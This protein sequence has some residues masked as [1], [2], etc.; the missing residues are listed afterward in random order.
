M[1]EHLFLL[2]RWM[3]IVNYCFLL[4]S[5]TIFSSL[6]LSYMPT[7]GLTLLSSLHIGIVEKTLLSEF[8]LHNLISYKCML[9]LLFFW[10]ISVLVEVNW[11]CGNTLKT[12]AN[13][14]WFFFVS[15]WEAVLKERILIL[16][17]SDDYEYCR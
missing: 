16:F 14:R 3:V 8:C 17:L 6:V 2:H 1:H 9:V 15:L 12:T 5:G 7:K 11:L 13:L 10:G 4:C